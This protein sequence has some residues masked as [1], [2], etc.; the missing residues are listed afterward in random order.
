MATADADFDIAEFQRGS[1]KAISHLFRLY[2]RGLVYF[3]DNIISNRKEA[4]DIVVECF[5]KLLKKS[6]DFESLANIRSFLHVATRNACYNYL[7]SVKV[8]VRSQRELAYL[9]D[10]EQPTYGTDYAKIDAE[11]METILEEVENLPPQCRQVFKYLFFERKTT[12]EIADLM[13]LSVKTVRNQKA[14]AIQLLQAQL[15]KRNL[16][17]LV[18]YLQLLLLGARESDPMAAQLP[19]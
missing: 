2:Y 7:Q 17:P 10:P 16:L 5:L 3:A 18:F 8:G 6:G 19:G 1:E 15:L 13:G 4:E 14:R 12:Q 9:Q 11:I